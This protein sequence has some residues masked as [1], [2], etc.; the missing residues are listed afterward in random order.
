VELILEQLASE[1]YHIAFLQLDSATFLK[2]KGIHECFKGSVW[3][4]LVE[5]SSLWPMCHICILIGNVNAYMLILIF[6][7]SKGIHRCSGGSVWDV[8]SRV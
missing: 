3:D 6:H 2:S 4:E 5:F 7:K 8:V 1:E